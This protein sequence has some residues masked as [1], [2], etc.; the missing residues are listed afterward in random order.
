MHPVPRIPFVLAVLLVVLDTFL[1]DAGVAAQTPD[2][3]LHDLALVSIRAPKRVTLSARRPSRTQ[4]VTVTFQN[5][6][7]HEETI[8]DLA[9]LNDIV[10][11]TVESLGDCPSPTAEL[12]PPRRLPL[13][14]SPRKRVKL[15]F[16][17]TYDCANHP[18]RGAGHEDW[19]YA[20]SVSH[21]AI[22]GVADASPSN[23][24]C[25]RAPAA[26]DRGCGA[27]SSDGTL[28]G[29]VFTDV[30]GGNIAPPSLFAVPGQDQEIVI[31]DAVILNAA[32]RGATGEPVFEWALANRP[33]E[34]ALALA[35][36]AASRQFI[37]PDVPGAYV[38]TLVAHDG[39]RASA[40]AKVTIT[41]LA[42]PPAARAIVEVTGV[43]FTAEAKGLVDPSSSIRVTFGGPVD[44]ESLT[45]QSVVLRQGET[46]LPVDLDFDAAS[47]ALTVRPR[48]P[49]DL[50]GFFRLEVSGIRATVPLFVFSPF[51]ASFLTPKQEFSFVGGTVLAPDGTG[52]EMV[53]ASERQAVTSFL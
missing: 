21:A 23:D 44:P 46:A 24:A 9:A 48:S 30:A 50:D 20:A 16:D 35:D 45:S 14:I 12:R 33:A 34:S 22:D 36:P 6:G 17:V 42:E 26:S 4:R 47:S 8:P 2:P 1:A 43:S 39:P 15:V 53:T 19:R 13:T 31:G 52:L 51:S 38:L 3:A 10:S 18:A 32:A 5:L 28:G 49:L 37:A 41:V 40:P 29:D 25:P 27:K 7:G 11:L